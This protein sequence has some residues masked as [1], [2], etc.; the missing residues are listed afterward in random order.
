MNKKWLMWF[1]FLL[2]AVLT[3]VFLAQG[4]YEFIFYVAVLFL[5]SLA[6][7]KLDKKYNFPNYALFLFSIWLFLHL[8]GGSFSL[9]GT[10]LYDLMI[11]NLVGAPLYILRYD[12]VIHFL[13]YFVI[14]LLICRIVDFHSTKKTNK[15]FM[16][17]ISILAGI[18]VGAINEILEF[19]T[20]VFFN[21][22]GVGDYF[23]NALDL[24]CNS[25][26]AILASYLYFR[27]RK[28][29]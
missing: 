10:R 7:F 8:A 23:N 19:L 29:Q 21:A 4:N 3:I 17:V 25:L 1:N 11:F 12:Q 15:L 26:G 20:V 22:T 9:F 24:I 13:C 18:G 5:V 6:L 27:K 16:I 2:L 14:T 28:T